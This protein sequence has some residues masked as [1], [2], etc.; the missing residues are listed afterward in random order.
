VQG[1]LETPGPS[2]MIAI[3]RAMSLIPPHLVLVT[4]K[5]IRQRLA[6]TASA[7]RKRADDIRIEFL[8]TS[9]KLLRPVPSFTDSQRR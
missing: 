4:G 7:F 8:I 1:S 9:P 6:L 3:V 2:L 5:E